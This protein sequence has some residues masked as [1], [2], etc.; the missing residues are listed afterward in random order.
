MDLRRLTAEQLLK[1]DLVCEPLGPGSGYWAGAPGAYYDPVDD[2]FYLTYRL[3]R[4]R[5]VQP[6]RGGEAR[7]ARSADG[8]HFEDIWAVAKDAYGTPS[9]E[10]SALARGPDGRWHYFTSLVDGADGLWCLTKLVARDPAGFSPISPQRV[11]WGGDLGLEGVKDPW[12]MAQGE[13]YYMFLS[14]A[15]AVS[16][17]TAAS[18]ATA[19][20]YSTG[21]C[22]SQTGLAVSDD[23][24]HWEWLG[25]VFATPERGWDAYCRRI[26]AVVPSGAG[27][28][29]FFDGAANVHQ[30]YE[31]CAGLAQS[32]DLR[33]WNSLTP[34]GPLFAGIPGSGSVRYIDAV[35]A[36]DNLYLYY[37]ICRPDGAHELRVF[38]L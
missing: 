2:A 27:Y 4:P 30:N 6:D 24:E 10:R 8:V 29:A 5:G 37:E 13:R 9:I 23:L 38:S 28:W 11:Y 12:I 35:A 21:D 33:D 22:L 15:V 31:E 14:V 36:R 17:T 32:A 26:T 20:I 18:H 19:D 25:V 1:G 3:R 16:S 7:I 34:D